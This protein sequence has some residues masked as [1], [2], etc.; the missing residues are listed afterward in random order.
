MAKIF[1]SYR[2]KDSDI[3]AGRLASD[4]SEIFG[5][6]MIFRDIVTLRPGEDYETALENELDS[7]VA[8]I[9]VIGPSWSTITD[10]EGRR[11]LEDPKDWVRIEISRALARNI[12]VIPVLI[13]GIMPKEKE[14]PDDLKLLGKR[15]ALELSDRHWSQDLEILAHALDKVKGIDRLVTTPPVPSPIL[16]RRNVLLTLIFVAVLAIAGWFG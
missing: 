4:L 9:A 16:N 5:A 8:L 11:L 12:L 10:G 13:S 1:I 14:L 3:A 15:Q 6:E 2:R 7:C